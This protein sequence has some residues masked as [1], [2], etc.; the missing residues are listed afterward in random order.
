MIVNKRLEE[1]KAEFNPLYQ[2]EFNT[3]STSIAEKEDLFIITISGNVNVIGKSHQIK[4]TKFFPTHSNTN[5]EYLK[6][7]I[8]NLNKLLDW[9]EQNFQLQLDEIISKIDR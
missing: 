5:Q 6:G 8:Y 3:S 1:W 2:K 4:I 7:D 9:M